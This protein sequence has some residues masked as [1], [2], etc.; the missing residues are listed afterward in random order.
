MASGPLRTLHKGHYVA[1]EGEDAPMSARIRN[2][3]TRLA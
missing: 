2:P 3:N 1:A